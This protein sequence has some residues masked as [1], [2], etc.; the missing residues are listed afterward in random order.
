[1]PDSESAPRAVIQ[2]LV[3]LFLFRKKAIFCSPV[4]FK[5]LFLSYKRLRNIIIIVTKK[6]TIV[7]SSAVAKPCL[8][9][10]LSG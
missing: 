2:K 7:N 5:N 6:P 8:C 10:D 9:S 3:L 1:M 4:K